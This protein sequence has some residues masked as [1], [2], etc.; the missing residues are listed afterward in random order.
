[1]TLP[2]KVSPGEIME[3]VL[4]KGDLA[5]LTPEERAAYY[6]KVCDSLGINPHTNPFAFMT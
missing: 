4:M 3:S 2:A 1:M 6:L 5:K